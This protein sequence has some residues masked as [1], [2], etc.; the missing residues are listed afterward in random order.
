ML[1]KIC[2]NIWRLESKREIRTAQCTKSEFGYIAEFGT[3]LLEC[4]D[5]FYQVQFNQ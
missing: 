3:S 5:L 1:F 2:S 4:G